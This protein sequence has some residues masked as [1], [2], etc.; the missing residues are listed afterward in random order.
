MKI[1]KSG[2]VVPS[3]FIQSLFSTKNLLPEMFVV[4]KNASLKFRLDEVFLTTLLISE[5]NFFVVKR[6]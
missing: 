6:V 5:N 1:K 4:A 3:G 2:L